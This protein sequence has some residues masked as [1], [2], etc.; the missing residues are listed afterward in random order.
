[1][2]RPTLEELIYAEDCRILERCD[3]RYA[4][5]SGAQGN[6]ILRF[7]SNLLSRRANAIA[8]DPLTTLYRIDRTKKPNFEKVD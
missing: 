5:I 7:T 4:G 8:S 2:T 6:R 3:F 1:M